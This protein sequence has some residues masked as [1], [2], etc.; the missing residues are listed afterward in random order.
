M[1]KIPQYGSV[2]EIAGVLRDMGQPLSENM[3]RRHIASGGVKQTPKTKKFN[4]AKVLA[5]IKENREKDNKNVSGVAGQLKAKKTHLECQVL[6]LKIQEMRGL[7]VPVDEHLH[8]MR[9]MQGHWNST[10]DHFK[11]E[12]SALTKDPYLLERLDLLVSN[13]RKMLIARIEEEEAKAERAGA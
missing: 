2:A 8:E 7:V 11:S 4:V 6:E 1:A 9:T 10:L 12:A 5:A 3:I 13:V